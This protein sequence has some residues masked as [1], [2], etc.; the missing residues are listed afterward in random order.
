MN[1]MDPKKTVVITGGSRG[2]GLSITEAFVS[3]GYHVFVGAR[4]DNDLFRNLQ[5]NVSFVKTDV[6]SEL[7]HH[8]LVEK[9]INSTGRLDV[10]INNAGYSEWRP[11]SEI[12]DYFLD[13]IISTNLKGAFW[14]CK[15]AAK[16]MIKYGSIINI[17]SIAGKRGSANNSAYVAT[18]FAMNGLTQS[19]AK[20]LGP[21]GIRVNGVCPVL[22]PTPGL[23]EALKSPF[24]PANGDGE[25]F[26]SKF[27]EGNS[28]LG[29]LPTGSE[30]A[31]MC[32][33]LA[34]DESSAITG[35]NINV[36]C[37]VF[38]Q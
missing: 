30:V 10:Y 38:P 17:S 1:T 19:L 23:L 37:G 4:N 7:D 9:A 24:A 5:G 35:Q 34:S 28:A 25:R 11:I 29:R 27:A 36:D 8:N 32:L 14:G 3:A 22:I 26:I 31:S 2:I 18:K 6:K 20:E 12:D 13:N 16:S 21:K 15:A 33:F